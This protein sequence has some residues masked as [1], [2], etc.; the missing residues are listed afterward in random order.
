MG[1][2]SRQR[3][4]SSLDTVDGFALGKTHLI[5]DRDTKYGEGLRQILASADVKIVLCPP[6]V[7]HI[8]SQQELG[9]MLNY[10]YRQAA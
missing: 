2:G 3:A 1:N 5:I 6:R 4:G 7:L 8:R 9:C 10:Y